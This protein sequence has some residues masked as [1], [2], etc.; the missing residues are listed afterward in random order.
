MW[1]LFSNNLE[2]VKI[3]KNGGKPVN[4]ENIENNRCHCFLFFFFIAFFS[5]F[6]L[7]LLFSPLFLLLFFLFIFFFL[8]FNKA[9]FFAGPGHWIQF[10][11]GTACRRFQEQSFHNTP[12][13]RWK[14]LVIGSRRSFPPTEQDPSRL[15]PWRSL[16][17]VRL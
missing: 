6:S 2:I 12:R 10:N 13:Y 16:P 11:C 7:Q 15:E 14:S 8:L 3:F 5:Y 1:I 4:W 9:N 17:N